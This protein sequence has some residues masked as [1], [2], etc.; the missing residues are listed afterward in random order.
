MFMHIKNKG[1]FHKKNLNKKCISI[2]L[3]YIFRFHNNIQKKRQ[4][5]PTKRLYGVYIILS[6]S[7]LNIYINVFWNHNV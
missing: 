3:S 2:K 6:L 5:S 1:D 4:Y 7:N